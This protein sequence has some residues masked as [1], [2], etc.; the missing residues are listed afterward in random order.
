[1]KS[2]LSDLLKATVA[3]VMTP[4]ALTIDVLTLP[5]SA[6]RGDSHPFNRTGFLLKSIGKNVK[7]VIT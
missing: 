5:A 1:M 2:N 6:E 3:I 4:V 7:K